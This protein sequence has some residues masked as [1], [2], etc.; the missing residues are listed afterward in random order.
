MD[1][2]IL[3]LIGGALAMGAAGIGAGIGSRLI[4][5]ALRTNRELREYQHSPEHQREQRFKKHNERLRLAAHPE[6]SERE[7]SILGLDGNTI[8]HKDGSFSRLYEFTLQETMLASDSAAERFCDEMARLLCLQLPKDAVFQW[9]YAVSQDPGAAIAQH[10]D[11]RAYDRIHLP[12]A[13]LHD[14]RIDHYRAMASAGVFRRERAILSVRIPVHLKSDQYA[15]FANSFVPELVREISSHGIAGI[16]DTVQSVFRRTKSDGVLRRLL[17][18]ER[19]ALKQAEKYFRLVELHGQGYLRP[20]GRGETWEALFRSHCLD[21]DSAPA[22]PDAQGLVVSHH[23]CGEEIRDRGLYVLHGSTPVSMISLFAPPNP[24]IYA[25]TLRVILANP[26]LVFRHTLVT[27]FVTLDKTEAK[28]ALRKRIKQVEVAKDGFKLS[29]RQSVDHDAEKALRDLDGVL[30]NVSG[31]NEALVKARMYVINYGRPAHNRAELEASLKELEENDERLIRALQQ[32]DGAEASREDPAALH[33]LYERSL[34]G[35]ATPAS[36]GREFLEVATSL[37][38]LTPRER[39]FKGS[40][41]PH[42]ILSTASGRII[43][44]DL[45]DKN[46]LRSPIVL[47][48]GAPGHGKT[49]LVAMICNDALASVPDLQI[50]ALDNGG[51]LAPWA[52]VISA[53]YLRLSPNDDRSF[54]IYDYPGLYEGNKPDESDISLVVLDAMML[55]GYP[56]DD[57]DTADLIAN[58]ARTLLERKADRNAVDDDKIEPTLNDLVLQLENYPDK[59]GELK[60]HAARIASRLRKYVGNRWLDAP[61]HPDFKQD[62]RCDVYELASLEGFDPDVR[63][64]LANR[65]AARVLRANCRRRADGAKTPAIQAFVEVWKIVADYPDLLKVIRQGGRTGRRDNVVTL[66]DT[67]HYDELRDIQDIA[68]TAGLRLIGPQN[69]NFDSLIR[70]AQLNEHAVAAINSLNRV[71]GLFTQWVM[72]A[73]VGHTQQVEVVQA[74]LSPVEFWTWANNPHE[75]NARQRV[76]ALRPDWLMSDAVAWLAQIY[77]RGLAAEGLVEIDERLLA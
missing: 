29:H 16:A 5:V 40:P 35:E 7:T 72:V 25:D 73:G 1:P 9:R 17:A 76:L 55:G 63:R 47:T 43:G 68:A 60:A 48:L 36:T 58:S 27:E 14:S 42:T 21:R 15:S 56:L 70:D 4:P 45:F 18:E 77:P 66:L 50:S 23:L 62:T 57:R 44:V 12:A 41:R 8:R 31:T 38:A 11:A 20:L 49:T 19:D 71:D 64:A 69:K 39:A 65:M 32:M 54:N 28:R 2:N 3:T 74:D 24:G 61:T 26:E 33:C 67:H 51:S 34:L 52:E 53:R 10:L 22:F 6:G 30:Y 75:W 46:L 37:A 13:R 59:H